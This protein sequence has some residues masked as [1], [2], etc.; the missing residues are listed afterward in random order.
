MRVRG[1]KAGEAISS[2]LAEKE[3]KVYEVAKAAEMRP[4]EVSAHR[5][6]KS[7]GPQVEA[8]LA[9]GFGV[10][11]QEFRERAGVAISRQEVD[12]LDALLGELREG[13]RDR[14]AVAM[15]EVLELLARRLLLVEKQVGL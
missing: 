7:V 3:L 6:G 2:L 12:L 1:Y 10:S 15:V 4:N 11:V 8:K 5:T 13:S 14:R 9:R